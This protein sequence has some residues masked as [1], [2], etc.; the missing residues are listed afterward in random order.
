MNS[1]FILLPSSFL[2]KVAGYGWPGRFAKAVLCT[3]MRVRLPCLPLGPD[4]DRQISEWRLQISELKPGRGQRGN[5]QSAISNP[6]S[7]GVCGVVVGTRPC[8]GRG[9]GSIPL[10]H[11]MT[12]VCSWE[13]RRFP[14][15]P[16]RVR[17]LALLL[18]AD[19][20]RHRKAPIS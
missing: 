2:R 5:L 17:F 20:A 9:R 15:P 10:G 3:E 19:V 8:E 12:G 14:K 16:G 11:P 13:S 4:G 7:C 6:Q 18:L 1:S